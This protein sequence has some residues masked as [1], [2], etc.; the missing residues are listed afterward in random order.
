MTAEAGIL[1]QHVPENFVTHLRQLA[2]E[3]ADETWLTVVDAAGERSY[4]YGAFEQR[5]RALAALLQRA[6]AAG[7]RALVMMDNDEHYA[8]SMLACFYSGVIAVPVPPLESFRAQHVER[9]MGIVRDAQARCV[10]TSSAVAEAIGAAPGP[11]E[12]LEILAADRIDPARAGDWT[13]RAPAPHDLAFLQYTSGSTSAPKGVMV[14]HAHLIANEIAIRDRMGIVPEDRLASWAPLYHDMGLIGG[15]MQP[16]FS[17]VPLVLTSPRYFLERPAR[18]LELIS[19]HRATVSGGPDFAYRLCLD[20]VK[21]SQLAQLDLST[22][23]VAYTGAEPVRAD[24][25]REFARRFAPAG[26]DP[27]AAYACYGLAEATLFVAGGRRGA[28]IVTATFSTEAL[29]RQQ[30]CASA[31]GTTLVACGPAAAGH[32]IEIVHPV[33]LLP[34]EAGQ[35]GEIWA[36]GPSIAG[37]YWGK[38]RETRA[39]FVERAGRRWLRTGDLGLFHGGELYVTGRIKDLIIVRGHNIYPQDIERRIESDVDA[40]RKGRVAAFAVDGAG[41]EGIGVAVEVSRSMQKRMSPRALADALGAAVSEAFRE[42]PAVVVLLNPGGMPKTSSGKLQRQ[43]CRQGWSDR[44]LDAYAICEHGTWVAGLEDESDAAQPPQDDAFELGVADIWNKALRRDD[45]PHLARDAHFFASGGNSLAAV[46]VAALIAERWGIEFPVRMLFEHPRLAGCAAAVRA[47]LAEGPGSQ[48]PAIAS[49][50]AAQRTGALPLSNAQQRQWFLWYLDRSSTAYHVAVA[51]RLQGPL[52][53]DA[54]RSA[55]GRTIA[56]HESL[57]TVFAA[58]ADGSARQWVQAAAEPAF[59]IVDLGAVSAESVDERAAGE[60]RAF[61]AQPFDLTRGPLLRVRLLRIAED[62]HRLLVVTHHIVSD[63]VSMQLLLDELAAHYRNAATPAVPVELPT[64]LLQYADYAA[65]HAGWLADRVR[66]RQLAYWRAQLGDTHP[67]LALPAD[68]PRAAIAGYSLAQHEFELAPELV[69]QLRQRASGHEATLFMALLAGFQA[70]LYRHTGQEDIRVGVPIANRH[71][72]GLAS[73][74]GFFVNTLVMRSKVSGRATLAQMLETTRD[75]ALGAQ[76]NQDL[77]FDQLVEALQPERSLAHPPLVQVLFNHLQE[78]YR[79]FER[80]TGLSV[81]PDRVSGQAAQFELALEVRERIGGRVSVRIDH[82]AELFAPATIERL[83]LHYVRMLQALATLPQQAVGDVD[84]LAEAESAALAAWSAGEPDSPV[85]DVVHALFEAQAARHPQRQALAF[86]DVE[87][88][89][90]QLNDEANRLA[91]HLIGLGVRAETRIGIAMERSLE[92]VVGLL[93]I[94]KTGAAYVPIDPEYPHERVRYMIE[95][96]GVRLVLTQAALRGRLGLDGVVASIE[97]DALD[98]GSRPAH[99]PQVP[100]HGENLVYLIYTSGSTGRP[101]GAGN[102]HRALCNRLDWGQRHQPLDAGDT[103]L[104]KT[105]FSFDISFWEFFWPLTVGARLAL[106]G[107]GEHRDPARLAA[108]VERHRITTIHFV[109]SMLQAFLSSEPGASCDGLRRIVCSGEALS[110]ELQARTLAAF[111]RASLLNLYGPTEAAIEVTYRDC[112]DEGLAAVP[113]GKPLAHVTTR[114]LDA[115]LNVVAQGVAGELHLGGLAL[116]RGYWDRPGLTAERFVADPHGAPGERLYRT[117]DLVRWRADGQID[118]L[119]RIDH[120]VKVRGFRIE[121]GEIEAALLNIP[122]VREAVAVAHVG[123]GDARLVAYLSG[124]GE[125]LDDAAGLKARL[126]RTLPD[127]MVPTLIVR[128]ERLPLNI[129]GKVD[130]KAL[131]APEFNGSQAFEAPRGEVAETIAAIWGELLKVE[132]VGAHDNFFDL[133]GHSLLLI[134]MHRL[135][136]EKL[137]S[138]LSVLDMFQFPTVASLARKIEEGAPDPLANAAVLDARAHRQREAL[139]RRR[140]AA[141]RVN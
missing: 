13:P 131:P 81:H 75:A 83:G 4:T 130:R 119:G 73:V 55:F 91:H 96:S 74:L 76:D 54:L 103:V 133:G 36:S 123:A 78:D 116:A 33:S 39:T 109:P 3:R 102:R 19:R 12:G 60:A 93:A 50:P 80:L 32:D 106:A 52:D 59:D 84:L 37:G 97:V 85:A 7:E 47:R 114:I 2:A 79:S 121:L 41:G 24:T 90:A 95:D 141:E 136:E 108:L 111:P 53:V 25:E 99:N 137:Q 42:A 72:P 132:K 23:R 98:L 49:L 120:Q 117:G 70:L 69:S 16:L 128:L 6:C 122:G 94:M 15:L 21:D 138:G 64:G 61:N 82:A 31:E 29:A 27:A 71:H 104:Q 26:F 134:R 63:G 124:E 86:G 92:M 65:W 112:S 107:P 105:P 45:A 88:S 11:F 118:Y 77:P 56:R 113:I 43:A 126:G 48:R 9:V 40:V 22:W 115:E 101:K 89:Y 46:Q 28:G 129:N 1:R 8:A 20:R 34:L 139:L 67:V 18:W 14:S 68:R 10:L 35:V 87:W 51:L 66:D 58:A 44:S 38:E 62:A 140:Q 110:A 30:G 125:L 17:G 127:Y 100:V 135:I 5:V 57:R